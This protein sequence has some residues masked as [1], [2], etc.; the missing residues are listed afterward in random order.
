M[1]KLTTFWDN[2]INIFIN[3]NKIMHFYPYGNTLSHTMIVMDN[4]VETEV[5]EDVD[6]VCMLLKAYMNKFY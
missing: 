1:I 4:G 6:K 5:Q 2:N 3:P